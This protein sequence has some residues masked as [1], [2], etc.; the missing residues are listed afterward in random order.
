M[1]AAIEIRNLVHE[2]VEALRIHDAAF[3]NAAL[4]A[5]IVA[6]EVAGPLQLPAEQ[7][8]DPSATQVWLDSFEE[9]PFVTMQELTIHAD[10]QVGFCH[11]LNRLRGR[12]KDGQDVDVTMR[13][14]LGFRKK[15]G[16]W[17][18]IHGHT[19]LPR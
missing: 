10:D 17:S 11:S 18:I 16:R 9:G 5:A 2:R 6:F 15:N 14:T 12:K 8:A 19:S 4:D 1:S 13:C 3:A 7:A